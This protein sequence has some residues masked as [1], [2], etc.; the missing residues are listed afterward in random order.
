MTVVKDLMGPE[1]PTIK[2]Y[3]R[4]FPDIKNIDVDDKCELVIK[5]IAKSKYREDYTEGDPLCI[6]FDVKK[7]SYK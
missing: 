6:T 1:S 7:V 4:D 2:L 5:V 3:E